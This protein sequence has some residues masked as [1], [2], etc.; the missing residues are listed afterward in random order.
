VLSDAVSPP[1]SDTQWPY[2][3]LL[4]H[5]SRGVA[6][7][8]KASLSAG[9]SA[10]HR[11]TD[12][13]HEAQL[14]LTSLQAIMRTTPSPL[15]GMLYR[16]AEVANYSLSAAIAASSPTGSLAGAASL[17]SKAADEQGR[18]AYDEPPAW[19]VPMSQV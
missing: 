5:Y 1:R 6:F 2:A 14:E 12:Y 15:P 7:A 10:A 9:P 19:H 8:A 4:R 3:A 18:W 13:L 11:D 17:L 16:Y